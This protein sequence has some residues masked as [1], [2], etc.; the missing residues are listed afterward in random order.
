MTLALRQMAALIRRG[1]NEILRV[2]GAALPGVVA[3]AIFM[4]GISA[5]F[6]KAAHLRGF[7]TDDFLA[8][9]VPVGFLQG[10]SFTGAAIGANLARDI[11]RG[12]FDRLLVSPAPRTVLLAGLVG[13]AAL[14]SLLPAGFLL[15]IALILGV[16]WPGWL[17]I[18][19]AATLVMGIGSVMAF[20]GVIVALRLRTQEAAALMQ[21]FALVTVLFTTAYAPQ[22]LLSGWM[23]DVARINPVT[24]VLE[25]V[26][27]GFVSHV[28]WATTWPA[29]VATAGLIAVLGAIG[30]REMRRTGA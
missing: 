30:V 19:L 8:F 22:K 27:Q 17:G 28:T 11:E 7:P 2:P 4:L 10:A 1:L 26:R 5:V 13:S 16:Q 3:P 9:V 29:L 18:A 24:K 14:R 21:F 23:A 25:G 6:G 15:P 12:W 20:W